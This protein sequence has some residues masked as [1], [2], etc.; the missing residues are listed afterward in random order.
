M[1]KRWEQKIEAMTQ[2]DALKDIV[3]TGIIEAHRDQVE[4]RKERA[5]KAKQRQDGTY[6]LL[7][8][9]RHSVG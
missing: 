8:G 9:A 2:S 7:N 6:S 3:L 1:K 4:K 5:A